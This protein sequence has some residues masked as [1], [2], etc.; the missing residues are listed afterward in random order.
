MQEGREHPSL[1]VKLQ[2][3]ATEMDKMSQNKFVLLAAYLG[4][5]VLTQGQILLVLLLTKAL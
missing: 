3:D 1:F 4:T 5:K 2:I